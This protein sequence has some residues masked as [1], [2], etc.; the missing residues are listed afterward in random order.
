MHGA[1]P[2]LHRLADLSPLHRAH[3]ERRLW[4]AVIIKRRAVI[5]NGSALLTVW[6]ASTLQVM[7]SNGVARDTASLAAKSVLLAMT[8]RGLQSRQR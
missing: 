8:V 6:V 2:C 7:L 5:I 1:H 4:R 3:H